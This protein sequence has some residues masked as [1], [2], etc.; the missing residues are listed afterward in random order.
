MPFSKTWTG[1]VGK[2]SVLGH[3]TTIKLRTWA[4]AVA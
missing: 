3:I 1:S 2:Q 4:A